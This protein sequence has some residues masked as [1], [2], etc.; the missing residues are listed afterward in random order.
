ME[1][2]IRA[3]AVLRDRVELDIHDDP[4][5]TLKQLADWPE[6]NALTE[7]LDFILK[8]QP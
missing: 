5:V 3:A 7:A 8:P 6:W 1:D 4:P 2:V